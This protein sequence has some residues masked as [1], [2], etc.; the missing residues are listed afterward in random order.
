VS[1][2][3]QLYEGLKQYL[4]Q[5]NEQVLTD[6]YELGR[7]S[8]REG[9]GELDLIVVYH[10]VLDELHAREGI[11][12]VPKNFELASSYLTDVL[13]P[14]EIRQRGYKELITKLRTN[15]NLLEK[16]I[17]KRRKT[18]E[19]LKQSKEKFQSLI[20]NAL[21]IITVL[22][23][24][25]T[26]RYSSPS[27]ER[28]L[29]FSPG[30]LK[31]QKVFKYLHPDDLSKIRT[32]IDELNK[33]P[34][35]VA[36]LE[37]RFRHKLGGWVILESVA[38]SVADSQDGLGIIVNSRDITYRIKFRKQLEEKSRQ[39][40]EA[41]HIARVGSWEWNLNP[42]DKKELYWSN[43]MCRIFGVDPE[44]FDHSFSS[45]AERIHPDDL[46][47]VTEVID[48]AIENR[49]PFSFEHR[50]IRTNGSERTLF[51]RGEV[52][53][54][55]ERRVTK[56]IGIGQDITEQKE[57]E[58]RLRQYSDKLRKLSARVEKT[59]E[60]ERMRI[61]RE[62][63]DELGQMLTVLKMEFSI[64]MDKII[65]N[66]ISVADRG[67]LVN[68]KE[69]IKNRLDTIIKS[70]QRIATEL[71]PEVLDD[72]GLA[73]AIEWQAQEFE[74]RTGIKVHMESEVEEVPELEEGRSTA[75]FRI[76]QETLTNIARHAQADEVHVTLTLE[77]DVL[78]LNVQ[79][80]GIGMSSE[81]VAASSSLGIT[82]M[83]ERAQ[84]L[85]GNL[86]IRGKPGEGTLIVL[87]MPLYQ[88][89]SKMETE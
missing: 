20:E 21:D 39:L 33:S 23:D 4:V 83:K 85:G 51:C 43:E 88:P 45:F 76:F 75:A 63:H 74:S 40:E 18:E 89:K 53:T 47:W 73:E 3:E 38:N 12:H 87:E 27:V 80:N 29:A 59:R 72:L 46:E 7:Y 34:G 61:A 48:K 66:K 41:Q 24:D 42:A 71:R 68:E 28:I 31:G 55:P 9:I 77:N 15:N 82:G 62:I 5:E 6:A 81:V 44:E 64:M 56:L 69:H 36:T 17:E 79:D 19:A 50:I 1:I 25:G 16:E 11:F 65:Q 26:I 54:D 84:L 35:K 22:N 30:E 78:L 49:S 32:T 13:A 67:N 2:K 70:V 52:I 8:L 60:E 58:K 14:Y 57:A 10:E 37:Y 86:R